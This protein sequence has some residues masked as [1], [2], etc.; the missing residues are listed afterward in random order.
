MAE[1]HPS[2]DVGIFLEDSCLIC[3]LGFHNEKPVKVTEK[4]MLS[5]SVVA[6]NVGSLN[7]IR[8]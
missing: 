8:I 6:K 3:K 1:R 7:F 5:L 2:E 4:G